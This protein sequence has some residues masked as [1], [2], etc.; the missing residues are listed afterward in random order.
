MILLITN[1]ED[2]HPT[3]VIDALK[4][5]G[6]E[7]FRFNT[8]A[9]LSDYDFWWKA[10]TEGTDFFLRD[11][12]TGLQIYGHDVT[13]VW[14]RRP[15]KP[16]SLRLQA[17]PE[18]DRHNL[19]EARGF[20]NYLLYF[21]AGKY[22]IGNHDRENLAD[23]KFEQ[24]KVAQ[25]L[26]LNTPA[27]ILSNSKSA[28]GHSSIGESLIIKP[29]YQ[30][31]AVFDGDMEY[32][33]YGKRVSR[34]ELLGLPEEAFS[35][36]VTFLQDYIEKKFE[37][38][39][40]V[41]GNDV[42]AAKIDSQSLP[43]DKGKT[44]WRQGYDYGLHYEVFNLPEE[45][46]DA[47]INYLRH[48]KLNFGAF[49]FIVTP[50]DRYV[51]LECNPNG[52]WMWIEL[53][54][55]E[56]KIARSIATHLLNAG[57]SESLID[58][59][60]RDINAFMHLPHPRVLHNEDDLKLHLADFLRQT[61]KYDDILPEYYV[62]REMIPGYEWPGR[63]YIDI[64]VMRDGRYLPIELKYKTKRIIDH[65]CC[66]GK[67]TGKAEEIVRTHGAYNDNLYLVW[68]DVRRIEHLVE[69]F[70]TVDGGIVLLLTNDP[71]YLKER[72]S[73]TELSAFSL[74]GNRPD[75]LSRHRM[76]GDRA[77]GEYC[78]FDMGAAHHPEWHVNE[79]RF[80][81]RDF[82]YLIINI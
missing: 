57:R 2:A 72:S 66:F 70:D 12:V 52:Q 36:T 27:T 49:D 32:V 21:I 37:L 82:N 33:F 53:E 45:I 59:V 24:L 23:S 44:D 22:S 31:C 68:K 8:E 63:L 6:V 18:I 39:I 3:P 7:L 34:Q 71:Y 35:Q 50:D 77:S 48:F 64:V 25:S 43:D 16:E 51:F 17:T 74:S 58:D 41:V 28:I 14:E 11:I 38:R 30:D 20:M 67:E 46:K 19:E 47:C 29:I 54:L 80:G 78:S 81:G 76:N 56:L 73:G 4:D 1:K 69:G 55:P 65:T 15:L 5:F 13:A 10:D 75:S 61:G 42:F 79:C 40:T 26:G 62:P 9:L 60:R